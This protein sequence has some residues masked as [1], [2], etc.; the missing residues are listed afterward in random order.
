MFEIKSSKKIFH[1]NQIENIFNDK[2]QDTYRYIVRTTQNNGVRGY[3]KE[4]KKF[5]NEKNVLSFAQDTFS[6]FYQK[7]EFFTGNKVKILKPKFT[8]TDEKI[9]QFFVSCFQKTL[10]KC[11]WGLGSTVL[12]IFDTK[13]R[14]PI[15]DEN[16]G[17]KIENIDFEFM[18]N[19]ISEL[20]YLI[21]SGLK[22]FIS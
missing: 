22:D 15:K 11:S 2:M 9:M 7:D 21:A 3:I 6:V 16:L 10:E 5:L 20:D 14:I 8:N 4:S 17:S 13:F 18:E 19:F 12:S 1:A